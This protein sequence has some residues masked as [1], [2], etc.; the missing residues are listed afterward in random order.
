MNSLKVLDKLLFT[1]TSR[2]YLSFNIEKYNISEIGNQ[3]N[4]SC[5]FLKYHRDILSLSLRLKGIVATYTCLYTSL[6]NKTGE[7]HLRPF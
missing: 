6:Y 3:R 5:N 4:N 2:I 7:N 1:S